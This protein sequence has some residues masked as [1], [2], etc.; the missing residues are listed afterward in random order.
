MKKTS[1]KE[2]P[3]THHAHVMEHSAIHLSFIKLG[4][5]LGEANVIQPP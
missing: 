4:L 2:K 1:G 5:I 3:L